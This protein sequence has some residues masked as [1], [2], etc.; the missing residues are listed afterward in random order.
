MTNLKL[1]IPLAKSYTNDTD[2][3]HLA[4]SISTTEKDVYGDWI[5]E[6]ALSKMLD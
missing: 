5:T 2:E 4:F 1:Q 6:K 3:Y